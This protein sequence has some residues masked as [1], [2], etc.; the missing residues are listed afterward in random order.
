ML[1]VFRC[2]NCEKPI[3][4]DQIEGQSIPCPYCQEVFTISPDDAVVP[5]PERELLIRLA[6]PLGYV[7]FVA[8]PLVLT[9]LYF[10]SR[11]RKKVVVDAPVVKEEKRV[12][13]RPAPRPPRKEKVGPGPGGATD[14]DPTPVRPADVALAPHPR[15]LPDPV[16]VFVAPDPR[17]V[18]WNLPSVYDSPWQKVGSVD[19]RISRV[20]V[21]PVPIIDGMR[22]V[23]DTNQPMLVVVMEVRANTSD[24][25]RELQSWTFVRLHYSAAFVA[26]GKELPHPEL[27]LGS[28]VN[29]GLPQM[30]PLPADGEPVRDVLLFTA[31]PAGSGE[32]SV[33]LDGDRCGESGDIWFKIPAAVLKK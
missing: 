14:P 17:A 8:V 21:G 12:P 26:S 18:F 6:I 20:S 16:E 11:D 19:L 5:N 32:V 2:P 23:R 22:Q 3:K 25:K 29:T 24:K 1:N 13:A 10:T 30:Q 28:R 27:P 33:R 7:L 31:P 15:Q 4:T 9:I